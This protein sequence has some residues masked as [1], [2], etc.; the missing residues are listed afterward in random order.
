MREEVS[1]GGVVL[2]GNAI[3][4]LKKYNGDWVLPKGKVEPGETHEETAL[5]E[6]KEETGVKASIDKYLGEIHY[7]YKENWDQTKSVHKMV[8]WYLMHTKNMDTQP[9]REEGFVEAKFV[10]VDRVVDMARYDDEKE[11]IKVALKEI[12]LS[13]IHI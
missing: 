12:K 4:L 2:V 6:V 9:Q 13:L 11:I 10:H 3:L 1:A 8:Y 5:R 7:T